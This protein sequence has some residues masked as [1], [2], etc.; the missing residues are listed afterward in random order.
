MWIRLWRSSR[1]FVKYG[2]SY[3]QENY[4]EAR[5]HIARKRS[6]GDPVRARESAGMLA[7]REP[8]AKAGSVTGLG[9]ERC[10]VGATAEHA[11]TGSGD[12]GPPQGGSWFG[13]AGGSISVDAG[14][15]RRVSP[16]P[17]PRPS[18]R[19]ATAGHS[20]PWPSGGSRP[21]PCAGEAG[22]SD[23]RPFR[24]SRG[25]RVLLG[26]SGSHQVLR[27]H[28][29][30]SPGSKDPSG[31]TAG[32]SGPCRRT[33]GLQGKPSGF[34]G[35]IGCLPPGPSSPG[36]SVDG[37]FEIVAAKP[38][39]APMVRASPERVEGRPA[40]PTGGSRLPGGSPLEVAV[41]ATDLGPAGP[42]SGGGRKKTPPPSCAGA[43]TGSMRRRGPCPPGHCRESDLSNPAPH[44]LWARAPVVNQVLWLACE[45][46]Y[47]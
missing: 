12:R 26:P 42:S 37:A 31:S 44:F 45:N 2:S 8:P 7:T 19:K 16:G 3:A 34:R 13:E 20:R 18:A 35:S 6:L 25:G 21:P 41:P 38:A 29:G 33:G 4:F 23:E 39:F 1:N 40:E 30:G 27:D 46:Y 24:G 5:F 10:P 14:P 15:A 22:R 28:G 17:M 32:P 11:E 43:L 47:M 36:G 9:P